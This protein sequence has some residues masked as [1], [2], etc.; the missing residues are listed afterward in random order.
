[1]I[2]SEKNTH[3]CL[4]SVFVLKG[5]VKEF[6]K[7]SCFVF[8]RRNIYVQLWN[9]LRESKLWLNFHFSF[10]ISRSLPIWIS[11]CIQHHSEHCSDVVKPFQVVAKVFVVVARTLLMQLLRSN[12]SFRGLEWL[13]GHCSV[14]VTVFQVVAR[15]FL[16]WLLCNCYV[17][18]QGGFFRV[19]ACCYERLGGC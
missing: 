12:S 7:I 16:E 19:Q 1:M 17:L 9:Y 15:V 8:S 6:F 10:N 4:W 5:I 14:V 18:L 13:L 2:H 11:L 3:T